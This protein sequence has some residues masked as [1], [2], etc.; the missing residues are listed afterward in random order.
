MDFWIF[1][2]VRCTQIIDD[3]ET[4]WGFSFYFIFFGYPDLFPG[5]W[6][7]LQRRGRRPRRRC[8]RR[9]CVLDTVWKNS[10]S[11]TKSCGWGTV[12]QVT[13]VNTYHRCGGIACPSS[14]SPQRRRHASCYNRCC[15]VNCLWTWSAWGSSSGCGMSTQ[16]QTVNILNIARN[17]SCSGT[18][19]PRKRNEMR[20]CNTGM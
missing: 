8:T 12:L 17:P 11:C 10:G 1:S 4:F 16:T 18:S 9:D 19:C 15:P 7:W 14:N 2:L 5:S 6:A 20:S 13:G 3:G